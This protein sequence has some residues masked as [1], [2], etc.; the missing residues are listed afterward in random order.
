MAKDLGRNG[1]LVITAVDKGGRM[2]ILRADHYGEVCG[3]HLED[4]AYE[5]VQ[6]FGSGRHK[7]HLVDPRTQLPVNLLNQ[8]FMKP[9]VTDRLTKL[10]CAQLSDLLAK[11]CADHQL[12]PADVRQLSPAHPYSGV[13]LCFYGLPKLHKVGRLKIR[14]IVSNFGV[15]CDSTMLHLKSILNLLPTYQTS[16]HHSYE[17]AGILDSFEF[18]PS[19]LLVSF[20]VQSLFTCVP[21]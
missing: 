8:H 6:S 5:Q 15:Y 7:V 9:D 19:H 18:E 12:S 3:V 13:V 11:L 4:S 17:L 21:V 2:V 20:D 16:V 10:Q 14:P 1:D